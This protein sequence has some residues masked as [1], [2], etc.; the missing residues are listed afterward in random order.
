MWGI[1]FFQLLPYCRF[2]AVKYD[3]SNVAGMT[4]TNTFKVADSCRSFSKTGSD[5]CR[6]VL[7]HGK[8]Q[9]SQ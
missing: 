3:G 9:E 2:V 1:K 8:E 6:S 5:A 7:T 4:A